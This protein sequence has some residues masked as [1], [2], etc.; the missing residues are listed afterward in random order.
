MNL[1]DVITNMKMK[2][3]LREGYLAFELSNESRV[4][5]L[6]QFKPKYPDVFAHHITI[7]FGLQQEKAKGIIPSLEGKHL[8]IIGHADDGGTIEA[9]VVSVDGETR[10]MDGSTYHVTWSLDKEEGKKP[11]HSNQLIKDSGYKEIV[12]IDITAQ[13]R[14]F[15]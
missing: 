1:K 5:L 8:Q 14:Y 12:P 10:R 7:I 6:Q 4:Q 3:I 2:T 9:L 15:D 11:F 13:G